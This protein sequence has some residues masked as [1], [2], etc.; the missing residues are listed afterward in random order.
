MKFTLTILV[1]IIIISSNLYLYKAVDVFQA[2]WAESYNF[3]DGKN[4]DYVTL[5][6]KFYTDEN[7]FDNQL[8]PKVNNVV[9]DYFVLYK[10]K[11]NAAANVKKM[12]KDNLTTYDLFSFY[13]PAIDTAYHTKPYVIWGFELSCKSFLKFNIKVFSCLDQAKAFASDNTNGIGLVTNKLIKDP[14]NADFEALPAYTGSACL[15]TDVAVLKTY[16]KNVKA[17]ELAGG[18]ECTVCTL[19]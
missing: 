10:R 9:G 6:M 18:E 11:N 7:Q 3:V 19:S 13:F 8:P 1:T 5:K 15:T 16:L 4:Y 2:I 17:P 12:F 14:S